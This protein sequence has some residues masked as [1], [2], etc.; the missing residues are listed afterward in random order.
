[1]N[2]ILIR[3][4][5]MPDRCSNCWLMDGEDSWCCATRG[6]HLDPEYRYGIKDKPDFCPLVELPPHG[7]LIDA[8]EAYDAL[9][10]R[11]V[12]TGYQSRATNCIQLCE[13]IIPSNKEE[14][15]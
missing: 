3:G 14:S 2:D 5:E 9:L 13:T 11:M 1:M 4:M 10:N 8:D 7:R 12:M 15:K 6:R